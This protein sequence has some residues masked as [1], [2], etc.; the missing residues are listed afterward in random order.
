MQDF[1]VI[2]CDD[3]SKDDSALLATSWLDQHSFTERRIIHQENRGVCRTL[4][5]AL[6]KSRG[7]YIQYIACDDVLLSD[8]LKRQTQILEASDPDVAVVYSDVQTI[9]EAGNV[10]D[11]VFFPNVIPPPG[12]DSEQF[13]RR[14]LLRGNFIPAM[15]TIIRRCAIEAVGGLDEELRY[16]DWDLWLRL[17]DQFEFTYSDYV[18]A[19]YRVLPTGLHT[20]IGN[21]DTY[22]ILRKHIHEPEVRAH[23]QWM[24][25]DLHDHGQLDAKTRQDYLSWASKFPETDKLRRQLIKFRVPGVVCR[26]LSDFKSKVCR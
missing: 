5:E 12:E 13:H 26:I 9:D 10:T 6:A 17:S 14:L 19:Q 2:Y 24:I 15:S 18:S 4:N 22:W 23:I 21:K 3:A 16:E 25:T 8:K 11:A 1:E 20:Q 7:T